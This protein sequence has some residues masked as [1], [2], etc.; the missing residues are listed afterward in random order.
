[1]YIVNKQLLVTATFTAAP[2]CT[3]R[4]INVDH[5]GQRRAR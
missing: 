4:R 2:P 1:M 3:Q 5:D